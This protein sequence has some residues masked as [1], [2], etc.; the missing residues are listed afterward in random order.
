MR[1]DWLALAWLAG[2]TLA[3]RQAVLL[4]VPVLMMLGTTALL[5]A[6]L[7]LW[8]LSQSG[9]NRPLSEGNLTNQWG[10]VGLWIDHHCIHVLAVVFLLMTAAVLG[11]VWA[12]GFAHI[13]M[14][15]M[16]PVELDNTEQVMRFEVTGLP[17]QSSSSMGSSVRVGIRILDEREK[18]QDRAPDHGHADRRIPAAALQGVMLT[19]PGACSRDC[20]RAV[21]PGQVWQARL[22][23]RMPHGS[24]NEAG[25][26]TEA[27]MLQQGV[28][29]TAQVRGQAL[30]LGQVEG[31][32]LSI[33]LA[34]LRQR[35]GER[36]MRAMAGSEFGGVLVA[37]S[38]GDQQAISPVQWEWF[39][40]AGMSHL[41]AISGT[42][43]SLLA[44]LAG[45]LACWVVRKVCWRP[46]PAQDGWL[47]CPA[48]NIALRVVFAFVG[49]LSALIYCLIAGWGI[50]AQRTFYTLACAGLAMIARWQLSARD[51][52]ALALVALTAADPWSV[53]TGGLWLSFGAVATLLIFAKSSGVSVPGVSR[54]HSARV[55]DLSS[56]PSS[57]LFCDSG[58]G[59]IRLSPAPTPPASGRPYMVRRLAS[60][61]WI[62]AYGQRAWMAITQWRLGK[63]FKTA[64]ALQVTV[65]LATLPWVA[66]QFNGV[67]LISLPANLWAVPWVSL[68]LTPAALV[69]ALLAGLELPE[70]WL[71]WL[72]LPVQGLAWLA[73][74]PTRWLA[75]QPGAVLETSSAPMWLLVF[76]L[77]GVLIA[78]IG[79]P[80]R[81]RWLGWTLMLPQLAWTPDGP[82]I[83]GWRLH[84][85]DVGQGSAILVQTHHHNVLFDTGWR[86][87]Q[88]DAV[89]KMVLPALKALGVRTIDDVII[90][91]PDL[92]HVGGLD[93]LLASR[94]VAR[95][96]GSGL[97]PRTYE[98]CQAGQGWDYDG[99]EFRF[100]A[101][102]G[103]CAKASLEGQERN[104]CSCVLLVQG[105]WHRALLPGDIDAQ[106]ERTILGLD[107]QGTAGASQL[108]DSSGRS[109]S[110][111]PLQKARSRKRDKKSRKIPSANP[112]GRSR[113]VRSGNTPPAQSSGPRKTRPSR[114]QSA[115]H[116][117]GQNRSDVS[118]TRK[119]KSLNQKGTHKPSRTRQTSRVTETLDAQ[120]HA[121]DESFVQVGSSTS[122][123]HLDWLP[124]DVV[125]MAHH[126][127]ISSSAPS[128]VRALAPQHAIA[129]AG[130]HNQFGHPHPKV[131]ARWCAQG[132]RVWSSPE[133]GGVRIESGPGGLEVENARAL[134]RGYW[135]VM[136]DSGSHGDHAAPDVNAEYGF[137]DTPDSAGTGSAG[138]KRTD[139]CVNMAAKQKSAHRAMPN[140]RPI[141]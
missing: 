81:G 36:I 27:R 123:A 47:R 121:Q 30:Y 112:S 46:V 115:H 96:R 16:L 55:S 50:P 91:H 7:G 17:V 31:F 132:A 104:R 140:G 37:L 88:N 10:I 40:R 105:A 93:R 75:T 117:A 97:V 82:P 67:S 69:L 78:L 6:S 80:V 90:S 135:H 65:T 22:R 56:D 33:Q 124:V 95:L 74:A 111:R 20:E 3:Q 137:D 100:V 85:F 77:T 72:A 122:R 136:P 84:A 41:V 134:R 25:P 19:W 1:F 138:E 64:L 131:I 63:Y 118:K 2:L 108:R 103:T 58:Y 12:S 23:L 34:R 11:F 15:S 43:V 61:L 113:T 28:F 86:H 120:S 60:C 66:A 21:S 119:N 79:P 116:L 102:D 53:L 92:D 13:R 24:L 83:G 68:V 73:L 89:R 8:H 49:T 133:N 26:D 139:I 54:T 51:G 130:H 129:Q 141:P 99:V 127:S 39:S 114:Q 32:S 52:L 110:S 48:N 18:D 71:Q 107:T 35:I 5:I 14:Q 59:E 106:I 94:Q 9:A 45:L 57:E 62:V 128:W 70:L 44:S 42:H 126:G 98:A 76:S 101:P 87:G 125:L 4:S 29:M 109:Q 38:I